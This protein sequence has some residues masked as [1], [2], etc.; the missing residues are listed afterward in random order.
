M[1]DNTAAE[2]DGATPDDARPDENGTSGDQVAENRP[3]GDGT[4]DGSVRFAD[5]PARFAL[6]DPRPSRARP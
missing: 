2:Q 3:T 6:A 4:D 5:V 1:S